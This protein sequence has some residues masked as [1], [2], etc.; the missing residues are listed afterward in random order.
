MRSMHAIIS[1]INAEITVYIWQL[2]SWPDLAWH[3][4]QLAPLLA[5][6]SRE[7]GLLLGRMQDIG[8][9]LRREAQLGT[10]TEDVVRSCEIEGE[11]LDSQQVRSSV[12]RR[13]GMEV[14]GM[15]P[16]DRNVE[17]VVEMMLD[18]TTR[19]T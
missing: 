7:Q 1:A 14:G 5:R 6:T 19:Y 3:T 18:A 8:F 12:A 11:K 15:M 10:L 4:A 17:G 16:A 2:K 9:E 13:L